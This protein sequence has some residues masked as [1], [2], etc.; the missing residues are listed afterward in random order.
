MKG[1][2]T[3]EIQYLN[4]SKY[5]SLNIIQAIQTETNKAVASMNRSTDIVGNGI[6][7]TGRTGD[8]FKDILQDIQTV[9][10]KTQTVSE[11][12]NQV[13]QNSNNMVD[14]IEHIAV[15]AEQASGNLQ[16]VSATS[17]EQNASMEE[18]ASSVAILN[19]MSHDLKD[20]LGQFKVKVE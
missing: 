11:I 13:N 19:Q 6:Q 7:M 18:I 20:D 14:M 8:S 16:Q 10:N 17:E 2:E 1:R 12:I 9:S 15:V 5:R 3:W 4:S